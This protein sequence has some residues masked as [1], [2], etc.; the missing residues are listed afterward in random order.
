MKTLEEHYD[1]VIAKILQK[2]PPYE[3]QALQKANAYGG[4]RYRQTLTQSSIKTLTSPIQKTPHLETQRPTILESESGL[5]DWPN[6]GDP[7]YPP[8]N[9]RS[10]LTFSGLQSGLPR[11][12]LSRGPAAQFS[13][14]GVCP[15]PLLIFCRWNYSNAN[16]RVGTLNTAAVGVQSTSLEA[17]PTKAV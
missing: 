13:S 16:F 14:G 12:R 6:L 8:G 10:C 4:I 5:E 7:T 11:T 9:V 15:C 2:L 3:P 1:G 17:H